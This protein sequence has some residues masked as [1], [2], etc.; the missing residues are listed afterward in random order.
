[1]PEF[2]YW[3]AVIVLRKIT[4]MV[5]FFLFEGE[6]AWLL[7]TAVVGVSMVVHVAAQPHEDRLTDMARQ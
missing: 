3:D 6:K 5:A 4:M 1:M 2:F 7:G